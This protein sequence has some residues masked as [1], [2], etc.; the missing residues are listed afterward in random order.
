MHS[1][2]NPSKNV[3]TWTEYG[4][5]SW[6]LILDSWFLILDMIMTQKLLHWCSW[7]SYADKNGETKLTQDKLIGYCNPS[8][9]HEWMD[10]KMFVSWCFILHH[11]WLW[12]MIMID[13]YDWWLWLMIMIDDYDWWFCL[14][15]DD[16]WL[17]LMITIYDLAN[18]DF[19]CVNLLVMTFWGGG[20]END[21]ARGGKYWHEAWCSIHLEGSFTFCWDF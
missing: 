2:W 20:D 3:G 4:R 14:M 11:W 7:D 8:K 18:V 16:W 12:L 6:F 21:P 10:N 5:H 13:D 15:I 17:W 1:C 19:A 9:Q